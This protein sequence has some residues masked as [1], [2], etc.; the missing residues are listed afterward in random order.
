[1]HIESTAAGFETAVLIQAEPVPFAKR[2]EDASQRSQAV[3]RIEAVHKPAW[4]LLPRNSSGAASLLS[5]ELFSRVETE[6]GGDWKPLFRAEHFCTELGDLGAHVLP[7]LIPCVSEIKR[8]RGLSTL[9]QELHP[10][11]FN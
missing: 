7:F 9:R 5:R 10:K 1:M 6:T 2:I 3:R 4:S 8:R 11:Q